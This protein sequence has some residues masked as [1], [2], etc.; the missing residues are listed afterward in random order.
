MKTVRALLEGV[1]D[2]AGIFS[3]AGEPS[4][5]TMR[6]VVSGYA[7]YAASATSAGF[8]L[9]GRLVLPASRLAE[10]AAEAGGVG[11][12]GDPWPLS[13]VADGEP[14]ADLEL[15][16][17]FNADCGERLARVESIECRAATVDE[18]RRLA[19]IITSEVACFV[20]IPIG[21]DPASLV[22]ALA[23]AG[24]GAR[25]RAGNLADR[26]VTPT[27]DLA[28][29][30][31]TAAEVDLP[32]RAASG[33][34]HPLRQS[35]E[36]RYHGFLNLLLAAVFAQGGMARP[37]LELLL[38]ETDFGAF[39]FDYDAVFWREHMA[40]VS[41]VR[42]TRRLFALS[43]TSCSFLEPAEGLRELGLA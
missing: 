35:R 31:T 38:E 32:F 11:G 36:P 37:E 4:S 40:V 33:L 17:R 19:A 2:Y 10:F 15:I 27:G 23:D 5:L 22:G 41:H 43:F 20:G 29:F 6:E 14:A 16:E 7:G 28:R 24:L 1:V 12:G 13:V 21:E 8:R 42:N 9:L 25:V 18:I 3:P 39:R 30:L 34:H 26:S